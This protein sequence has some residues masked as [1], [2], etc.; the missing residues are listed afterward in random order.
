MRMLNGIFKVQ[1]RAVLSIVNV[2]CLGN[3]PD[4]DEN[5]EM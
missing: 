3:Y 5:L 1:K 2:K 4:T